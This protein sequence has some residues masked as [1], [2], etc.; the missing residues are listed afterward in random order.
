MRFV[1]YK[2]TVVALV[3][4]LS[5]VGAEPVLSFQLSEMP[6][7][8]KTN[9][10]NHLSGREYDCQSVLNNVSQQHKDLLN[11]INE[12]VQ[13]YGYFNTAVKFPGIQGASCQ[14]L[15]L[16]VDLG[17]ITQIIESNI[18]VI[19]DD[20]D[21]KK[22][23]EFR[24]LSVGKPLIQPRYQGLK[25]QL[26]QLATEKL[27]LDAEFKQQQIEVF[28]ERNEAKINVL[29]DLGQRYPVSEV[30]LEWSPGYDEKKY[31]STEFIERLIT[32]KAGQFITYSDLYSLKQKL[33]SYGYFEQITIKLDEQNKNQTGVPL[34][35]NFKPASK[36]DYSIGLGFSTDAGVKS[37]LKY[38]NHRV[39]QQGHQLSSQLTLSQL[40]NELSAVYK[41][42]STRYPARKWYNVQLAYRDETTD[43][44]DSQTSILGFSQTRISKNRW[45][46]INFVDVLHEKFDTGQQQNESILLVPGISWSITDAD[47]LP[48][49]RQGYRLQTEFKGSSEDLFSDASFA[50]ITLQGKYIH[51]LGTKNRL[52]LRGQ[53]GATASSDFNEI[54]TTYRFFA[55]GD[56]NIRGFDYESISPGNDAGDLIGGKHQVIGSIEFEHQ[57]APQWAVAAFTDFGDAFTDELDFKHSVGAGI[58][59]FSPIGPIRIDLGVPVNQEKNNF[60]LHITIGPDL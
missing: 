34:I 16:N 46:N 53:V 7:H 39:N 23:L 30:R 50:Q 60:R 28:P 9:I 4:Y 26:S 55:G 57:F 52:L 15:H 20:P 11:Q 37:S 51:S 40:S 29:F 18:N 22:I 21:F 36:Y 58:R 32:I 41:I 54:P 31:F 8:I 47:S 1:I 42:P 38:N 56:Q 27:Y 5:K 10:Q 45:Q 25:S 59:W 35:I 14:P 44:V 3:C 19:G 48:R 13:P 17:P 33:N 43:L 49:P 12:A 2:I 6:E 24:Q